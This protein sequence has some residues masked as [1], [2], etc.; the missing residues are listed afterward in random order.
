TYAGTPLACVAALAPLDAFA[1]DDVLARGRALGVTVRARLETLR[2]RYPNDI[3]DVRGLGAMLALECRRAPG[4]DGTSLAQRLVAAA[5][6]EGLVALTAGPG[7]SALR[8]LVPLVAT[9]DD[10][11]RGFAALERAAARTLTS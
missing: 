3:V 9:A 7:S 11:E 10:L 5:F 2:A 1:N 6:D 4:S 8:V